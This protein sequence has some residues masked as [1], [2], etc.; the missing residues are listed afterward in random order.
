MPPHPYNPDSVLCP[1]CS[2]N[3]IHLVARCS[4]YIYMYI[5]PHLALVNAQSPSGMLASCT[6]VKWWSCMLWGGKHVCV[7]TMPSKHA[8]LK[9]NLQHV[10]VSLVLLL[11]H[12]LTP[13]ICLFCSLSPLIFESW[14]ANPQQLY[15]RWKVI[16]YPYWWLYSTRSVLLEKPLEVGTYGHATPLFVGNVD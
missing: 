14:I 4:T 13:L 3:N 7:Q 5:M 11:I 12:S 2:L 10:L 15:W 16:W 9:A 8:W 1:K 6:N